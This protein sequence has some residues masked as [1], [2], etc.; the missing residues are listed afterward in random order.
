MNH[1]SQLYL[2]GGTPSYLSDAQISQLM[3]QVRRRFVLAD[4]GTGEYTIEFDARMVT[5]ARMH[6]LRFQGFNRVSLYVPD[7]DPEVQKAINRMQPES[8]VTSRRSWNSCM[9]WPPRACLRST[10]NGSR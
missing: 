1:L 8:P 7:I 9:R 4:D 2:G 3:A 5:S 6:M 10:R